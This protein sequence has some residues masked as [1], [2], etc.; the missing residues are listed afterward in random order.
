M[1]SLDVGLGGGDDMVQ[2]FDKQTQTTYRHSSMMHDDQPV[3]LRDCRLRKDR[4]SF[5]PF[6]TTR[7]LLDCF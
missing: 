4:T 2:A 7:A 1:S 5:A 3:G 6:V